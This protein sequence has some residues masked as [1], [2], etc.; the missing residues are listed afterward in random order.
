MQIRF[1]NV[2][3]VCLALTASACGASS[4]EATTEAAATEASSGGETAAT[5]A[6]VTATT[7]SN[8]AAAKTDAQPEQ[9]P[10]PQMPKYG[11]VIVHNVKD[12]AK[13]QAAFDSHV[14]ARK[15]AGA[16][17]DTARARS[18][19]FKPKTVAL[20]IPMPSTRRRWTRSWPAT[21]SR[22]R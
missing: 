13:W 5:D 14:Q 11:V 2:L 21:T 20:W 1:W 15:D 12:V 4:T 10:A 22:R 3:C 16:S 7:A 8:E 9:P 17:S 6:P 19:R 18:R